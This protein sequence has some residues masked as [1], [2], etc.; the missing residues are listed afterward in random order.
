MRIVGSVRAQARADLFNAEGMKP[1][2]LHGDSHMHEKKISEPAT[3]DSTD[4]LNADA[5]MEVIELV[6]KEL[7][8]VDDHQEKVGIAALLADLFI[9]IVAL[10]TQFDPFDI[11]AFIIVLSLRIPLL[12]R[13]LEVL[14]SPARSL[15]KIFASVEVGW[16]LIHLWMHMSAVK[17]QGQPP[18]YDAKECQ[19]DK[20]R[21]KRLL[22]P[23]FVQ[24]QTSAEEDRL[25]F[26]RQR[27]A[28]LG[29]YELFLRILEE[30]ED[31]PSFLS[32]WFYG[33]D[34]SALGLE[35]MCR[36]LAWAF[37]ARELSAVS[38]QERVI[39]DRMAKKCEEV[40]GVKLP[41]GFKGTPS[42][43]HTLDP[44]KVAHRPLV[45]YMVGCII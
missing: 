25:S 21:R 10:P 6:S 38:Q 42:I 1:E 34:I 16:C 2:R 22:E 39:L 12:E 18:P 44:V 19:W 23:F 20:V 8:P 30:V 32:K 28:H 29:S 43:R 14:P 36:W 27:S 13:A 17:V 15:L 31:F 26:Q 45:A 41:K 40:A 35:D 24:E 5:P 11:C 4:R 37:F 3:V 33:A 9:P 7:E